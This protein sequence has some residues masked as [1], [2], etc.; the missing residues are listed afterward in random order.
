MP[1]APRRSVLERIRELPELLHALCKD[2]VS[3][4]RDLDGAWESELDRF[5]HALL[6]L[7]RGLGDGALDLA[8]RRLAVSSHRV[9]VRL[10]LRRTRRL[11][12]ALEVR[13]LNLGEEILYARREK[14]RER[15]SRIEVTVQQIPST[16]ARV[17][18]REATRRS[19]NG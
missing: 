9:D 6:D 18:G 14:A 17:H 3:L 2:A 7:R 11:G 1:P 10:R 15:D 16:E 4:Q 5:A 8:P 19:R 12:G 13:V